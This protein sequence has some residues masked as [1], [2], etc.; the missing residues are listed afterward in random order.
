VSGSKLNVPIVKDAYIRN[1]RTCPLGFSYFCAR[2]VRT[3]I[4]RRGACD[5]RPAAWCGA[6]SLGHGEQAGAVRQQ[7]VFASTSV[8]MDMSLKVTL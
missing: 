7:E 4:D 1:C 2:T 8:S 5:L 6:I 3:I